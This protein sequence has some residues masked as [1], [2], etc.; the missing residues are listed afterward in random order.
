MQSVRGQLDAVF[1]LV[2]PC[3][4]LGEDDLVGQRRQVDLVGFLVQVVLLGQVLLLEVVLDA[5]GFAVLVALLRRVTGLLGQRERLQLAGVDEVVVGV[6][7]TVPGF[8]VTDAHQREE[9]VEDLVEHRLVTLVF[10]ERHPQCGPQDSPGGQDTGLPSAP[11]RVERLGDR[12]AQP[13]ETQQPNEAVQG[14]FHVR[15]LKGP[16]AAQRGGLAG[17]PV[18]PVFEAARLVLGLPHGL[19]VGFGRGVVVRVAVRVRVIVGVAMIM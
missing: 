6:A 8:V 5:G 7:V 2:L 18:V 14:R 11:H 10:D 12:N 9:C 3:V 19:A 1:V 17:S 4:L 13:A 16:A 15:L